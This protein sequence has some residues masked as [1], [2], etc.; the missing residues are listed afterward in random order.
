M[1]KI[2][3][4]IMSV[5]VLQLSSQTI[6]N[7][8]TADGLLSNFVECIDTDVNNNIWLGTSIG[9]Q[10]FDGSNWI[11]YTTADGLVNDNVKVLTCANNGN[12]WVGTD[13]GSSQFDGTSW[14]IY[15]NTNGLNSNQ[16][17]SID[18]DANGGIWVGTNQGV[19]YFDGNSWVSYSSANLHWSGVNA[20]AFDSNGDKW[21]AT[22]LG[23]IVH[24]D[25]TTFTSHD[26]SNGLLSQFVTTLLIDDQDNKWVGTSSGMSVFDATNTFFTQHTRMYI[27][28]PPDTLN[29]IV[30]IA[31]DSYGRIWT[32]IYV[33]YL[34]VGGVAMWDG[35]QWIDFD[36]SD[37]IVGPNVKGLAIDS[38]ENIWIATS[39]GVS[40]ISAITS[41]V[42][43][44]HNNGFD[45]FPNPSNNKI[46]ITNETQKIQQLKIY[47]NLGDLVYE[48]NSN[49]LH[50]SID[51]SPFSKGLYYVNVLS[52]GS[53]FTKKIMV[54]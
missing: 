21:F 42:I 23:G 24:F 45:I 13:F 11:T 7:Y 18:E 22:P 54:N 48:N 27:M 34:A 26:T 14:H 33:G 31:M 10:K 37:G 50:Y 1:K 43:L 8:T 25:G 20:T 46:Y 40:K 49:L 39:T 35:N 5:F 38:H 16:V 30:D 29:P 53:I 28:P 32:A 41:D 51:V 12:I 44:I 47:N 9:L 6:T 2:F 19:S 3:P 4:L 52:S 17:K 36:V 15:N